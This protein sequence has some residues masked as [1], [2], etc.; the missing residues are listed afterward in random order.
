MGI[1]LGSMDGKLHSQFDTKEI[2]VG[3]DDA[4]TN[5]VLIKGG[6]HGDAADMS[7][8]GKKQELRVCIAILATVARPC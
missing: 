4:A 8:L 6:T 1:E 2:E 3:Y 5:E 7:R